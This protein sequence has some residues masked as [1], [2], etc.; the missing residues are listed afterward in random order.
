[1]RGVASQFVDLEDLQAAGASS[2]ETTHL[3]LT[4][5]E[6][7]LFEVFGGVRRRFGSADGFG[8]CTEI[9][10]SP[11]GQI[12]CGGSRGRKNRSA[13]GLTVIDRTI[14][15]SVS[16]DAVVVNLSTLR[17]GYRNY[18]E[19]RPTGVWDVDGAIVELLRSA[20]PNGRFVKVDFDP[21][22]LPLSQRSSFERTETDYNRGKPFYYKSRVKIP[23]SSGQ[24]LI[25]E[26]LGAVEGPVSSGAVQKLDQRVYTSGD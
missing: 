11:S 10:E 21:S 6:G 17:T 9:D 7:Q 16:G 5:R 4:S 8:Q 24:T 2:S 13:S 20:Q 3:L 14:T 12:V 18:G 26:S 19:G 15:P 22:E 25:F 23:T 1:M